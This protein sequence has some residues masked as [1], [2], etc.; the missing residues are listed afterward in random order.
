MKAN[1][2]LPWMSSLEFKN[3]NIKLFI[4]LNFPVH[5]RT[6][7]IIE[8]NF[9]FNFAHEIMDTKMKHFHS[10]FFHE[11]HLFRKLMTLFVDS[12]LWPEARKTCFN[13]PA[14]PEKNTP[15]RLSFIDNLKP[16]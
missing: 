5:K 15:L 2:C 9:S 16:S 14:N 3:T 11:V 4:L 7:S 6:N 1:I 10:L 12:T 13:Y 8:L